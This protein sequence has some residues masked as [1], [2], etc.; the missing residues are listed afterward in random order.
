[1]E[2]SS[3]LQGPRC[4]H[5]GLGG[6]G[7]QW[8]P[9]EWE[10]LQRHFPR[11]VPKTLMDYGCRLLVA[12]HTHKKSFGCR[13]SQ[14]FD[15]LAEMTSYPPIPIL[16]FFNNRTHKFYFYDFYKFYFLGHDLWLACGILVPDQGLNPGPQKWVWSLNGLPG[17]SEPQILVEHSSAQQETFSPSL[18]CSW[19]WLSD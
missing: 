16:S 1:M 3:S 10:S 7:V 12:F 17:N 6:S 14:V 11:L 18:C 8:N 4:R 5:A 15:F 9:V 13:I 2:Q 19:G